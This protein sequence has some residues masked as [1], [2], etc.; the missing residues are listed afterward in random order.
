MDKCVCGHPI[1]L[2]YNNI[3]SFCP[4]CYSVFALNLPS[5]EELAAYYFDFNEDYHG[6][7]RSKEAKKRQLRYA[8]KYLKIVERFSTAGSLID[9][10][11]SNNPFPDI[12]HEKGYQVTVVDYVRP[13]ELHPDITFIGSNIENLT[14]F[15][16]KFDTVTAFAIIEHS[17]DPLSA[18]SNL[19]K[20]CKAN[21]IIIIYIPEIGQFSDNYSL[22]TS[23]WLYP[24]EH[25]NL[26]SKKALIKLMEQNQCKSIYYEKF[27]LNSFRFMIRY[28]IGILE[29]TI[30]YFTKNLF[31]QSIWYKIRQTRKSKFAGLSMFV[32]Q[33]LG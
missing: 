25:L 13:K 33:K 18:I 24:P 26:L 6:G 7:G 5:E 12:A 3:A 28:G 8:K 21:G 32:F 16:Q 4:S 19:T 23:G 27:E 9:I 15:S 30:G 2:K 29:G 17:K 20:L 22:G 11:S 14:D 1:L 10:G 31:G